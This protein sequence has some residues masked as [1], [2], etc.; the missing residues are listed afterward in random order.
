MAHVYRHI[1]L[2]TGRPF[3]IGIGTRKRAFEKAKRKKH[4]H[5]IV[6]KHGYVVEILFDDLPWEEACLKE[7]EFIALY[8]RLDKG[9]GILINLTDGGEGSFGMIPSEKARKMA[10]QRMKG[11]KS[12]IGRI[13][14]EDT[15]DKIK[16]A[17]RLQL[18]TNSKRVVQYDLKGNFIAE[19]ESA[20]DVERKTDFYAYLITAAC[21]K[22]KN[23]RSVYKKFIWKYR[24]EVLDNGEAKSKIEVNKLELYNYN[25]LSKTY[26][27]KLTEESVKEIRSSSLTALDLAQK[28]GV[29]RTTIYAIKNFEQWKLPHIS[30]IPTAG[31]LQVL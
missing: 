14:S 24:S 12:C 28:F 9:T 6:A 25:Y 19:Y 20:N 31:I 15:K 21:R 4:W 16:A 5:N 8:G 2:D 29:T 10:S 3:Y 23:G 17:R 26:A 1:R 22:T 11:N 30:T 18:P 27:K 7:K 13:L